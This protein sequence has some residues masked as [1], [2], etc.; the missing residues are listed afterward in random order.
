M[1]IHY[2]IGFFFLTTCCIITCCNYTILFQW[3]T[4]SILQLAFFFL[5]KEHAS[6]VVLDLAALLGGPVK[7][8]TNLLEMAIACSHLCGETL[9][10]Y[11]VFN[12]DSSFFFYID[13][14]SNYSS[15][16]IFFMGNYIRFLMIKYK[17]ATIWFVKKNRI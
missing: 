8:L 17:L 14:A 5:N 7:L 6:L 4:L 15:F 3:E 1:I 9:F 10:T 11:F 13:L 12:G 16:L 2:R